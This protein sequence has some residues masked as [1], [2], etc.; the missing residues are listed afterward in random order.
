MRLRATCTLIFDFET[1]LSLEDAQRAVRKELRSIGLHGKERLR[2][3]V[4]LDRIKNKSDRVKILEMSLEDFLSS[5][6]DKPSRKEFEA[7]GKVFSVKMNQDRYLLFRQNSECVSCGLKGSRAFLESHK[8]DSSPHINLYGEHEG[9]LV[10]MTKDHIRAKACGGEDCLSNYQ[11]MCSTCNTL[12]AHSNLSVEDVRRL[13]E[14]YDHNKSAVPR[15]QLHQMVEA[16]RNSMERPWPGSTVKSGGERKPNS[17]ET[18]VD[19]YV[20]RSDGAL[21]AT[22]EPSDTG[23]VAKIESGAY[24]VILLEVNDETYCEMPDGSPV[25]IKK[26]FLADK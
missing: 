24:L 2:S 14:I 6:T 25:L 16:A 13:R 5:V 15:R 17:V 18:A 7:G 1:D 26:N 19:L 12:K 3:F 4:Q 11:T 23:I 22:P 8:G 9:K 20:R 21:A 10:L